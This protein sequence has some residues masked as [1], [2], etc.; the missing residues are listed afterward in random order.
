MPL[1]ALRQVPHAEGLHEVAR[2]LGELHSE[3][4]RTAG[5]DGRM[6]RLSVA[7]LIAACSNEEEAD[8]AMQ[9]VARIAEQHPARGIIV[10]TDVQATERIEADVTLQCATGASGVQ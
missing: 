7:T 6:V 1:P 4:L 9:A 2:Q 3:L 10:I 8:L 5:E